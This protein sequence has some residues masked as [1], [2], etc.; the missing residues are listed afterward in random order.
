MS[1][2]KLR[3]YQSAFLRA[4]LA[5][6]QPAFTLLTVDSLGEKKL[7]KNPLRPPGGTGQIV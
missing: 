6:D 7:F 2:Y 3:I 4:E 5:P 1:S